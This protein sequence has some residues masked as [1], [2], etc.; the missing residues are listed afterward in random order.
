MTDPLDALRARSEPVDPDPTFAERLRE[1]LLDAVV[2][3]GGANMTE[4]DAPTTA[5]AAATDYPV[6]TPYLVVN[7]ARRA[8][9]WYVTVL[10]ATRRGDPKVNADGTIGHAELDIG[11]SVLMLAEPSDLWPE[12]PVAAPTGTQHSH[13]LHLRVDEVDELTRAAAEHGAAVER[14]PRDQPYGRGSV[15]VD[16]F[17][18]RWILLVPP[19]RVSKR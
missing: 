13:S 18:H 17:G 16:P 4:T 5:A 12:V 8:L 9:D 10:G 7:D 11:G 15:I 6:L 3:T 19:Q 14:P 1:R 2:H